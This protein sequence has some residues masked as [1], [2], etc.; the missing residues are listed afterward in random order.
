MAIE[1]TISIK[2]KTIQKLDTISRRRKISKSY[3]IREIIMILSSH[4]KK[5]LKKRY[6]TEYQRK[7]KGS[8]KKMHIYLNEPFYEHALDLRRFYRAS[9]SL[10][11]SEAID[12]LFQEILTRLKGTDNYPGLMHTMIYYETEKSMCWKHIWGIPMEGE[13]NMEKI[14]TE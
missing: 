6:S 5:F 1:T 3:V 13:I 12:L 9:L 4:Q 2:L 14:K 11:I 7:D 8:Y 10:L